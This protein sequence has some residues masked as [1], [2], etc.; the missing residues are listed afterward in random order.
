M[1][2]IISCYPPYSIQVTLHTRFTTLRLK[3]LSDKKCGQYCRSL[4][5]KLFNSDDSYMYS[6]SRNAQ[7][8]NPH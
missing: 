3:P 1:I 4:G 7:E 6:F 2:R 8:K 5:L